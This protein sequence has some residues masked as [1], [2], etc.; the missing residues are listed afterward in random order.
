M[1]QTELSN[2]A[3]M[4]ELTGLQS[5]R[6]PGPR[7]SL[8]RHS[9]RGLLLFFMNLDGLKEINDVFGSETGQET[10]RPKKSRSFP[11]LRKT[12]GMGTCS[13]HAL[14]ALPS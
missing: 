12:N 11:K 6:F 3:L 7:G 4:D 2:L 8:A 14:A 5:A 9:D 1:V 13:A 10:F